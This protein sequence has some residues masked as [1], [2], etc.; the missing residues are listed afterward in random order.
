MIMHAVFWMKTESENEINYHGTVFLSFK[1]KA[2]YF[3][4]KTYRR[5]PVTRCIF[6]TFYEKKAKHKIKKKKNKIK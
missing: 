2:G 4:K 5:K 3:Q 1:K 6:T